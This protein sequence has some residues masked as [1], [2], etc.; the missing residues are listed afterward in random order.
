MRAAAALAQ[1]WFARIPPIYAIA[2][3]DGLGNFRIFA[4]PWLIAA[5]SAATL[6]AFLASRPSLGSA[7]A[8]AAIAATSTIPVR[9][10]IDPA[11]NASK[12]RAFAD[13][14]TITIEGSVIREP[15]DLPERTRLYVSVTR[16]APAGASLM[17]SSG[18]VRVAV[19][20]PEPF[21]VGDELRVTAKIRFPRND[22]NPG[23]FDYEGFMA[24]QGVAA[25]MTAPEGSIGTPGFTKLGHFARFPASAIEAIR[26]RIGGFID[27]N[28]Q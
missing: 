13:G 17:P 23:E 2:L 20:G 6:L 4:A 22:G 15:E 9:N 8:L 14:A 16:A 27:D 28:L 12:L 5:L 7:I 3:G 19:L 21:R 26:G 11:Y 18:I 10:L 25:T 24:R 1:P